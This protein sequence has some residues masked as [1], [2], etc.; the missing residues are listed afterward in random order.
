M[1]TSALLQLPAYGFAQ[2]PAQDAVVGG[3]DPDTH[4][5][6]YVALDALHARHGCVLVYPRA[7]VRALEHHGD[8]PTAAPVALPAAGA[9]HIH[10][11]AGD[12]LLTHGWL[13]HGWANNA[14]G[15]DLLVVRILYRRVGPPATSSTGTVRS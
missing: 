4:V 6:A 1:V 5:C 9:R 2:A 8:P 7:H 14:G 13:P 15:R 3:F 10:L 11:C 12:V